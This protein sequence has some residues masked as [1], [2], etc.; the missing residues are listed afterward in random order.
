MKTEIDS[1]DLTSSQPLK[2]SSGHSREAAARLP[3]DRACSPCS[4]KH[5][6]AGGQRRARLV[7]EECPL[8]SE[9][10][11]ND[12]AKELIDKVLREKDLRAPSSR[13]LRISFLSYP[14]TM[15][16]PDRAAQA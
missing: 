3:S 10:Q 11:A 5:S 13:Q 6:A 15:G 2:A 8:T 14:K 7:M 12:T 1:L 16:N 4:P 9:T